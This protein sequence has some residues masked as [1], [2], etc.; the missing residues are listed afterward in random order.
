MHQPNESSQVGA[1]IGSVSQ[2]ASNKSKKLRPSDDNSSSA[3]TRNLDLTPKQHDEDV[4]GVQE[5]PETSSEQ[6]RE[7]EQRSL[8]LRPQAAIPSTEVGTNGAPGPS[9]VGALDS[10]GRGLALYSDRSD[11]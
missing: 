4:S 9:I 6:L 1:R 7:F 3:S 2:V 11:D 5:C 10:D 8:I